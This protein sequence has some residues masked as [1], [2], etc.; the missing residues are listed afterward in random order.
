MAVKGTPEGAK[1]KWV[2]RLSAATTEIQEGV[3]RV[4][5]SPGALAVA[6]RDKWRQ[7]LMAAEEKWVRN[8]GRV[9][10]DQW[11]AN[12]INV[13]IPRI[14][15]GAQAKQDK[16]LAFAQEFFP[17]LERGVAQVERM[18]DTSFE[19]RVQRA[20]AMMRHNRS[21]KRGA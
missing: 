18:P 11:K 16:Y 3:N 13:G 20:V 19:E 12:M 21:F 8:T 7:N 1:N 6:K 10:L 15:Q 17:H 4:T 2:N 14:A 9:T 5:Q